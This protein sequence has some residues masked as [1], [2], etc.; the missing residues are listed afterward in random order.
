MN[1]K[2]RVSDLIIMRFIANIGPD[3]KSMPYSNRL[4]A[5]ADCRCQYIH[6]LAIE[7]KF[8]IIN[9]E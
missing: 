2:L 3:D 7:I 1:D 9:N 6:D 4:N 8:G 5:W